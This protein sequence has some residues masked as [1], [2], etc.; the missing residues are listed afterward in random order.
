[1]SAISRERL[2][3]A[4]SDLLGGT[5]VSDQSFQGSPV[6]I[7]RLTS[8]ASVNSADLHPVDSN[9]LKSNFDR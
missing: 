7:E 9:L 4:P 6:P 1:M 3:T 8:V 5:V 2:L